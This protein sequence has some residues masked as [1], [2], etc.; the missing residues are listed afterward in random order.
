MTAPQLEITVRGE[1][2][3][4]LME[5]DAFLS[6]RFLRATQT[7]SQF[8]LSLDQTGVVT[9]EMPES[10][11]RTLTDMRALPTVFSETVEGIQQKRA[12]KN[13]QSF[14]G[15]YKEP[16]TGTVNGYPGVAITQRL[17]HA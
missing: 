2:L 13:S 6:P 12:S 14:W 10:S 16:I 3:D 5:D 15:S 4:R 9:M 8:K 17:S 1:S 7:A 11:L